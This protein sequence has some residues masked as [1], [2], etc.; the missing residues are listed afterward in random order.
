LNWNSQC[1]Y[2]G[3]VSHPDSEA[4]ER[5]DFPL[6]VDDAHN[7]AGV[8]PHA[9]NYAHAGHV[10]QVRFE[11]AA[12][13]IGPMLEVFRKH[14]QLVLILVVVVTSAEVL[15]RYLLARAVSQDAQFVDATTGVLSSN[16]FSPLWLPGVGP[17]WLVSVAASALLTG[18]L[19]YGVLD[20]QTAGATS[21]GACLRRGLKSLPKLFLIALICKVATTFGYAM[22]V[23][24]GVLVSLVLAVAIP[25][26]VAENRRTFESLNRSS[27]LTNGHKRLIFATYFLWGLAV[28]AVSYVVAYS[29]T[30]GGQR[31]SLAA[32][33]AQALVN[34]VLDSTTAVLSVF[35]F[36]GLLN[37][38]GQGLDARVFAQGPAAAV[39]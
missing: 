31:G 20:L 5:C 8:P 16:I 19:A 14:F 22:L 17:A 11:G 1:S 21:A 27:E 36:L 9:Y 15:L 26:A 23:V 13:V 29:F 28:I 38:K 37:E 10:P 25:A 7:P 34:G 2:C 6:G 33:A 39:R 4:C 24:P 18:S 32:V 35:I 12:D 3:H 30:Y